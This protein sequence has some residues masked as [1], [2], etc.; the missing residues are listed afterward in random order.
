MM[1]YMIKLSAL[2]HRKIVGGGGGGGGMG[3]GWGII[4]LYLLL[5]GQ[6][7]NDVLYD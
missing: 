2:E 6:L 4:I 5:C 3:G 1:C 7:T